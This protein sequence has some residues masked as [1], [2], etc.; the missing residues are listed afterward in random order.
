MITLD[1]IINFDY[2]TNEIISRFDHEGD[3][4]LKIDSSEILCLH[5]RDKEKVFRDV[6]T[7][8]SDDSHIHNTFDSE[9]NVIFSKT[10]WGTF[11]IEIS[12]PRKKK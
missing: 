10:H 3:Y 12:E 7:T 9:D 5:F 2:R 6:V 8:F 11:A 4:Q 1:E